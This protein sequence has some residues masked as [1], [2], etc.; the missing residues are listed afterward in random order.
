MPK[1]LVT[2]PRT[3][4]CELVEDVATPLGPLVHSCTQFHPPIMLTLSP[5]LL[6]TTRS[7]LA[8][9]SGVARWLSDDPTAPSA[10]MIS[11]QTK[12][13]ES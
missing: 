2:C 9:S 8:S 12:Y 4:S 7:R 3:G 6:R 13:D 10:T 5:I 11:T 1:T